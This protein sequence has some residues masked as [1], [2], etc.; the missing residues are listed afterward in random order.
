MGGGAWAMLAQ[1]APDAITLDPALGLAKYIAEMSPTAIL[2]VI[3][4][5]LWKRY[6]SRE[7]QLAELQKEN[8]SA[9]QRVADALERVEGRNH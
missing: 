4:Y 8:I 1:A 3:V 9:L 2:A 6:T 5:M 7:D